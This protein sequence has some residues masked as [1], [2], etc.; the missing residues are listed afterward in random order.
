MSLCSNPLAIGRNRLT[1]LSNPVRHASAFSRCS[2]HL[3]NPRK[4]HPAATRAALVAGIEDG[5]KEFAAFKKSQI[6]TH[7]VTSADF[8]G[9]RESLKNNYLYRYAG[10]R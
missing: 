7:K 10:A 6:D 3:P 5:K 8:F 9:I 4:T 1:T 2:R